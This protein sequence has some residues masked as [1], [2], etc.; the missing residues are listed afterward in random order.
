MDCFQPRNISILSNGLTSLDGLE[1]ESLG[2]NLNIK[3]NNL[4][5]NIDGLSNL[6]V[7]PGS[8]DIVRNDSLKNIDGLVKST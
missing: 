1:V 4:L 5:E 7:I 8:I 3:Y 6:Q 2:R